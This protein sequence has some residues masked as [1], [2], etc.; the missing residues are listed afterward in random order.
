MTQH[1]PH[2]QNCIDWEP[3]HMLSPINL[4]LATAE[5]ARSCAATES[6]LCATVHLPLCQSVANGST[7]VD[8]QRTPTSRC[9]SRISLG[10]CRQKESK[11]HILS[12]NDSRLLRLMSLIVISLEA[13]L[14][15]IIVRQLDNALVFFIYLFFLFLLFFFG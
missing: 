9:R 10:H 15:N 5:A 7:V 8:P 3:A 13:L 2:P 12:D 6:K 11:A 14:V 4:S 1:M